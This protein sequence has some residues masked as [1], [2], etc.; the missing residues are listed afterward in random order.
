MSRLPF[1]LNTAC[2]CRD[3]D[4]PFRIKIEKGNGEYAQKKETYFDRAKEIYLL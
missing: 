3:S 4:R 1:L 2:L